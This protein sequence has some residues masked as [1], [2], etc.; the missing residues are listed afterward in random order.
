VISFQSEKVKIVHQIFRP[1]NVREDALP[2]VAWRRVVIRETR[3]GQRKLMDPMLAIAWGNKIDLIQV[4]LTPKVD[5]PPRY[6]LEFVPLN[7]YTADTEIC[8]LQWLGV[9]VQTFRL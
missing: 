4:L 1:D 3:G 6:N 8:G 5:S 7:G 9:N 2:Y